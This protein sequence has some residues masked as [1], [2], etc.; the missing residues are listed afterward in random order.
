MTNSPF[1][2]PQPLRVPLAPP[3]AP[4]MEFFHCPQLWPIGRVWFQEK[5][6]GV[7]I[8]PEKKSV[9]LCHTLLNPLSKTFKKSSLPHTVLRIPKLAN[10]ALIELKSVQCS[11]Q[12][13]LDSDRKRSL[14]ENYV[15]DKL[16]LLNHIMYYS[17]R[18]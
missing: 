11:R 13:I 16:L 18:Q 17:K 8:L 1:E 6:G 15:I 4:Q 12:E 3:G 7:K 14:E 2:G 9:W 5:N 10:L